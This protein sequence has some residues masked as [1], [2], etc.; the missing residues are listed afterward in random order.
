MSCLFLCIVKENK[1][2]KDIA[3]HFPC[4]FMAQKEVRTFFKQKLSLGCLK[5]LNNDSNCFSL[6]IKKF[7]ET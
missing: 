7:V 3:W 6:N 2:V 1:G 4:G 5:G